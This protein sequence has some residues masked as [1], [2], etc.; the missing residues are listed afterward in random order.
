MFLM[1]LQQ[2]LSPRHVFSKIVSS[3]QGSDVTHPGDEITVVSQEAV[4]GVG[5]F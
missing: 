4:E 3:Y 1:P 2:S 5:R